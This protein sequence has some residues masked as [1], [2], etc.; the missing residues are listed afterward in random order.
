MGT[1]EILKK[2]KDPKNFFN[3]DL[4]WVEFNRRVLE[5]ALNPELPLLEKVKFVSIFSSNLD[6]F[7]MIRV[8][9]LKEQ[10]AANIHEPSIDGLT[11]TEQIQRIEKAVRPMIKQMNDLWKNKIVPGLKKHGVLILRFHEYNKKQQQK[12]RDYFKKEIY[13]VLTPLAFDPGRPFPYISN[14]SLSLAVLVKKANGENHFARVKVPNILPRLLQ[15]NKIINPEKKLETNGHFDAKFVW[16]GDIIRAN[17]DLLF[18][19]MEIIEA[20]RFRIT[21]DTDIELQEDEADDL[22][23]VIEENIRQRRFGSVVRLEVASRMPTFMLETL[24]EN[25][26]ITRKDVLITDGPIGLSDVMTLYNIPLHQLKQKPYYPVTPK[27]FDE[28][29]DDFFSII[30]QRDILLHHPYH[31]FTPVID[32]IKQASRDPNVLAIKQTLYRVGTD[33]P[34]VKALIEAAERGKQV[35]VLVELKA[36]FDE[37]NNIFWARELEKVG[38]HVV[39][40]LVGLKTHAK[41]TLVVRKEFDGVRRYVHMSTGNYN[42]ITAKLYTDLGLFTC[43]NDICSDVSDLFNYLTGYSKQ[44]QFRKLIVAPINMRDKMV[45]KIIREIEN[46]KAGGEGKIIWKLN[47]VVDPVIISALYEASNNG[48]KIDLIVRGICCLIPGVPK[49]SENIKVISVVGRYLEHSRVFYFFNSGEEEIL[50]SS[51][52]MMPRNLDRRVEISFPIEDPKLKSIIMKTLLKISLKDNTK[53]RFLLP[54]M[55]YELIRHENGEKKIN[56]QEWLMEHTIKA[57]G[58]VVKHS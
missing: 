43:D 1:K 53:A 52:D 33:S 2:Y 37:E 19:G 30:K 35:A 8:S 41:M 56:S 51:A 38:V 5:E 48:V 46:V 9:G 26:Q 57:G 25:L 17:L 55:S 40:G 14:L 44:K 21:R 28:E 18:P 36:R 54:D 22:L 20:H 7:Y 47:S 23:R 49:L 32:F 3:R 13:P 24:I 15:V 10:I 45:E 39:Y 6:E 4:S 50:L 16:L 58:E 42:A 34:I 27:I 29:D 12:L 31:S 11:P